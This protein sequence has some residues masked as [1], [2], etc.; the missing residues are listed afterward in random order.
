MRH[1]GTPIDEIDLLIAD[2]TIANNFVLFTHNQ[3][4]FNRIKS[5]EL[6]DW[7]QP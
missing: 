3:R 1:D 5:Q 7:S 2:V 4:H 6:Q